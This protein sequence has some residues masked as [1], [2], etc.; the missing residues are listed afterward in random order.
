VELLVLIH[1]SVVLDRKSDKNCDTGL[2]ELIY[3]QQLINDPPQQEMSLAVE[4]KRIKRV[5]NRFP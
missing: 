5:V 3:K 2:F 4:G 1:D